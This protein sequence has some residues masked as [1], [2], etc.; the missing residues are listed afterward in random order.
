MSEDILKMSRIERQIKAIV[1]AVKNKHMTMK[2]AAEKLTISCRHM[3]RIM[4]RYESE[5]DKGLI[6]RHR[7]KLSNHAADKQR[8]MR[9]LTLYQTKYCGFGPTLAAEKMTEE[10]HPIVA[11]TLRLWLKTAGLWAQKRHRVIYRKCRQRRAQFGELLQM[12][13]SFHHWFGQDHPTAC[14]MNLVDD[15][16]GTTMAFMDKEETTSAAMTLLQRWIKRYGVPQSL[17]VDLKT[18]YVSPKSWKYADQNKEDL[19]AFTHFSKACDKLGIQIIKAFSPQAKGRV[20]RKHAVFQDRFVKEL[21]LKNIKTLDEA[22][23]L[24]K[25]YFLDHINQKFTKLP[26]DTHN[27]HQPANLFGDLNQIFCYE[28][29]RQVQND[30]TVRFENQY[31]QIQKTSGFTLKSKQTITV[32]QHLD[33]SL[34]FWYQ[35]HRLSYEKIPAP[36]PTPK[37]TYIKKGYSTHQ[38]AH[39]AK[40][41]KLKSPWA[42]FKTHWL[43]P[44]KPLQN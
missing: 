27:A 35:R 36:L 12:D 17:Y 31:Y 11:E 18:V 40:Q 25:N 13:G 41:N 30:W 33:Q 1:E 26:R 38:R 20:E 8:K 6:H 14:L 39:S 28:Y 9:I 3:R 2:A 43:N 4:R 23:H 44:P 29:T 37:K 7:G 21:Q 19:A 16:T 42:Q 32:R 10:G 24:L 15:A 5:G 22:N 34:S